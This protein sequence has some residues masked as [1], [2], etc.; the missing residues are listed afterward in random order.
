M[1]KTAQSRIS[2]VKNQIGGQGKSQH[3][4]TPQEQGIHVITLLKNPFNLKPKIQFK[5]LNIGKH[6]L[7]FTAFPKELSESFPGSYIAPGRFLKELDVKTGCEKDVYIL[8]GE[9]SSETEKRNK[10]IF[11]I[12]TP[13][14]EELVFKLAIWNGATNTYALKLTELA[15]TSNFR[16]DDHARAHY[17]NALFHI[18]K[19]N[20]ASKTEG[21]RGE[22]LRIHDDCLAS[23]D[24]IVGFLAATLAVLDSARAHN[25]KKNGVEVIID[26][27]ATAQGILFL[28]AFAAA[29]GIKIKID[30]GYLAFGLSEGITEGKKRVHANYITYPSELLK[31]L[32]HA[33]VV[34]GIEKRKSLDGNIYVVG[35]MGDAQKG[36]HQ[37]NMEQIRREVKE[38]HYCPWNDI[39]EDMHGDH[40]MRKDVLPLLRKGERVAEDVYFPNGGY[41]PFA[42]DKIY[43]H[44][45]SESN[46]LIIDATRIWHDEMGYGAAFFPEGMKPR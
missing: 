10:P 2:F 31:Q 15:A 9:R 14:K 36:I 4:L 11:T 13:Q 37:D 46:K 12:Q 42:L 30:A 17:Q 6:C 20:I 8:L 16:T 40:P 23:G 33:E 44:Q 5:P 41:W 26:G 28:K 21:R 45:H 38:R 19:P 32:E 27:P 43:G 24:S 39:R 25:I 3:K 34:F 29:N 22:A 1:K 18:T 7:A 35:D